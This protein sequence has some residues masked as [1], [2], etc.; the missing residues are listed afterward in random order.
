[1]Q[2]QTTNNALRSPLY[3]TKEQLAILLAF[4]AAQQS[5]LT[6]SEI[7][8]RHD[9]FAPRGEKSNG[10]DVY[11]VALNHEDDPFG[12]ALAKTGFFEPEVAT[13][14]SVVQELVPATTAAIEY[15]RVICSSTR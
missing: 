14:L 6:L 13:I 15:L 10:W 9:T 7:V 8:K 1:M 11:R 3:S 5:G 4:Q 2:E 12:V